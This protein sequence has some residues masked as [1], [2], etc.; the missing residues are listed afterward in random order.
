M[1][2]RNKP[3]FVTSKNFRG[4]NEYIDNNNGSQAVGALTA[5]IVI[6]IL[7]SLSLSSHPLPPHR[8]RLLTMG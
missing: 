4:D 5:I 8:R 3:Y 6:C 2:D 1:T 7:I